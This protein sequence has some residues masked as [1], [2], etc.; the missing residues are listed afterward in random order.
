MTGRKT[1]TRAELDLDEVL[2]CAQPAL[3]QALTAPE[4]D[5]SPV[6]AES[7]IYRKPTYDFD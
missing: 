5:V 4:E 7:A 3:R 2:V 6:R 1:I